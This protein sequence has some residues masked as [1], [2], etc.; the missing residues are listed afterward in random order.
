MTLLLDWRGGDVLIT[1][2][3]V[4]AVVGNEMSSWEIITL[5]F[6]RKGG[7]ILITKG[8]VEAVVGNWITSTWLK[9]GWRLNY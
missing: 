7:D 6:D 2:G 3:V 1:K 4:K 8:V 5:L 9:R